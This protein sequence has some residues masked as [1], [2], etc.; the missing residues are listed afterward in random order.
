MSIVQH[1]Y[2]PAL[3]LTGGG[4][5]AAYQVGVLKGIASMVPRAH[6]LPFRILTGTSAGALNA[7]SLACYSSN[8]HLAVKKL[9]QVWSNFSTDQVYKCSTGE[10]FGH[11][12][13]RVG[14]IFQSETAENPAS[15][16]FDNQPLRELIHRVV[17]FRKIDRQIQ[18]GYLR[19]IAINASCYNSGHSIS[20]FEGA[21]HYKNWKRANREGVRSRLTA[22]HLMAS[23]AIPMIFPAIELQHKFY[24]DGA[25]HQI[26]P[27][28]P[29]VHLGASKIL[30]IGV[31]QPHM[32]DHL[33]RHYVPSSATIAGH[34]LDTIFA[35]TLNSDVERMQRI[36]STIRQ[37]QRAGSEHPELR[38]VDTLIVKPELDF[39]Q[40]AHSHFERMPS[41]VRRLL[42]L[43]GV[44]QDTP[45]SI[46]SY[47]LFEKEYCRELIDIGYQ[48]ALKQKD[49]IHHFLELGGRPIR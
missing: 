1:S 23:A 48:D 9:E 5:R 16:L 42:G 18:R 10:V 6:P 32:E 4:A 13:S 7:A 2:E 49:E 31:D 8:F 22:E 29:P 34:L 12:M 3:M 33:Q 38:L 39:N 35:D 47:L 20:F 44:D 43:V 17:D 45:S 40:M 24:G 36:N 41:A 27:L 30:V 37:L 14:R 28:S 26:S 15:S 21:S 11:L 25:I 46:V 19:A